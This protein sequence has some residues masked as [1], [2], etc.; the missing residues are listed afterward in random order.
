MITTT[1]E[2]AEA[3]VDRARG[4]AHQGDTGSVAW[5]VIA[6]AEATIAHAALLRQQMT[7]QDE[8]A[9]HSC[10]RELKARPDYLPGQGSP[11]VFRCSCGCVYEHQS[12][13]SEGVWW[14]LVNATDCPTPVSPGVLR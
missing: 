14:Q 9:P 8:E 12:E 5:A 7:P 1:I 6:L 13:E 10:E 11:P 3:S 4:F 2:D